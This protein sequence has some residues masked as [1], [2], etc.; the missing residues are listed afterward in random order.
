[1]THRSESD[2][3]ILP[4]FIAS[5]LLVLNPRNNELKSFGH[6]IAFTLHPTDWSSLRVYLASNS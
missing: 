3:R 5:T 2:Y 4:S 1:M 6:A